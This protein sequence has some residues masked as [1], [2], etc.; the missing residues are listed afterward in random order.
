M[1]SPTSS[2]RDRDIPSFARLFV[3]NSVGVNNRSETWSDNN[4]IDL[5]RHHAVETR[6]PASTCATGI[7]NLT[8]AKAPTSVESVSP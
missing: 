2:I 8:D 3:A 5:F 6:S 4:T 1:T 7:C